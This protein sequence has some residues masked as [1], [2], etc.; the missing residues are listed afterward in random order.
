MDDK[1]RTP[2]SHVFDLS[3]TRDLGHNFVFEAS[4]IG[5]LGRRLLQEEDLAMPLDIVDPKSKMN[6]FGAATMLT[7]AANAGTDISQIAPIPYW[8][9]LFP[10]AGGPFRQAKGQVVRRDR[11]AV[12]GNFILSNYT[13]TQAMYD[14]YSC[15]SG[16]ET[17]ALLYADLVCFPACSQLPGQ[18]S[19]QA[20]QFLGRS[21][22]VSLR[23]AQRWKQQLQRVAAHASSRYEPRT[24]V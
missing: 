16:N 10:T 23:L 6:Y 7:K 13:N 4:Y 8:E 3:I 20:F 17:T 24:A 22:L 2:Y 18:T 11:S 21:V 9:N 14:L 19:P 5:R 1:L 12:H 15:F